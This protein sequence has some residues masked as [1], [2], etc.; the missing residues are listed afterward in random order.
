MGREKIVEEL[1]KIEAVIQSMEQE[2]EKIRQL[3]TTDLEKARKIMSDQ[4][5]KLIELN[6]KQTMLYEKFKN[7]KSD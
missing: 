5:S 6:E 1:K 4:L 3:E 2:D 7:E